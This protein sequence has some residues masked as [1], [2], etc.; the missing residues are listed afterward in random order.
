MTAALDGAPIDWSRVVQ[1]IDSSELPTKR[2]WEMLTA[3]LLKSG[4]DPMDRSIA[5]K[6][7]VEAMY[8]QAAIPSDQRTPE[9]SAQVTNWYSKV[10]WFLTLKQIEYPV[11]FDEPQSAPPRAVKADAPPRALKKRRTWGF[12]AESASTTPDAA[13]AKAPQT[14]AAPMDT[15]PTASESTA[16]A[17]QPSAQVMEADIGGLLDDLGDDFFDDE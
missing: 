17:A 8:P 6:Q 7:I 2:D 5:T 4:L 9:Q 15:G 3:T 16:S 12:D 11:Q 10:K 1:E 13:T 14:E